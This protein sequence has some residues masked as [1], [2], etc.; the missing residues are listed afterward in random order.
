METL[1]Q[2]LHSGWLST[3]VQQVRPGVDA[4]FLAD[5]PANRGLR[6]HALQM[7][8]VSSD[9]VAT[10]LDELD[11]SETAPVYAISDLLEGL[12]VEK[13]R[14]LFESRGF[15]YRALVEMESEGR[16]PSAQDPKDSDFRPFLPQDRDAFVSLYTRAY[17]EPEGDYW[18]FHSPD[19][20]TDASVFLDQ[21]IS[22]T[23]TW[24]NR[25]VA[26]ASLVGEIAGR[27]IGNVIVERS[28]SGAIHVSGLMVDPDYQQQGIGGALLRCAG[29]WAF[30]RC[31]HPRDFVRP[32]GFGPRPSDGRVRPAS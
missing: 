3:Y 15:S 2:G 28:S 13:Q 12:S 27:M 22:E 14:K 5:R 11:R 32:T 26:E 16:P 8:A 25:F 18:L 31:H 10:L 21:F 1:E 20:K 19:V 4:W 17:N 9:S 24:A 29:Q 7:T 6:I 30:K 23:G